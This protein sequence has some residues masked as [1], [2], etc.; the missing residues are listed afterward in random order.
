MHVPMHSTIQLFDKIRQQKRSG[1]RLV[2]CED[3]SR[4]TTASM[5]TAGMRQNLSQCM[6]TLLQ[7]RY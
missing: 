3:M 4:L 2:T 5:V 7:P 6:E 1:C